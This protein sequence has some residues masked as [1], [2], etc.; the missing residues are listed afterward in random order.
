MGYLRPRIQGRIDPMLA[1][2]IATAL[3]AT[4]ASGDDRPARR[5]AGSCPYGDVAFTETESQADYSVRFVSSQAAADCVIRW[6]S[7]APGHGQWR[8]VSSWPDFRV[9][10]TTG[11]AD[12]TVYT[13]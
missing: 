1:L 9:Y 8:E 5:V 6:T 7:I 11:I 4:P 12:L 3:V 2:S 10:R 13:H